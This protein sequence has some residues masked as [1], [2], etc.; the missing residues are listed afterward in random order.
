[1]LKCDVGA[2]KVDRYELRPGVEVLEGIG[3]PKGHQAFKGNRDA[4]K[5]NREAL[6]NDEAV[7][8]RDNKA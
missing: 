6:K 4:L 7:L 2:L 1:M 8:K 5:C 3:S